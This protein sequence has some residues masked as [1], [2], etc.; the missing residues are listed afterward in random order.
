[1]AGGRALFRPKSKMVFGIVFS[2]TPCFFFGFWD[3]LTIIPNYSYI[4]LFRL[5]WKQKSMIRCTGPPGPPVCGGNPGNRQQGV[6]DSIRHI[7]GP[8]RRQQ[9]IWE[10]WIVCRSCCNSGEWAGQGREG[11]CSFKLMR[12]RDIQ[13]GWGRGFLTVNTAKASPQPEPEGVTH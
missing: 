5:C 8:G 7:W 1:M 13:P 4:F 9:G 6:R 10:I 2:G 11:P 3:V 12:L